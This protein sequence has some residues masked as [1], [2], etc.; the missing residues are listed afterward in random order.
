MI[1]PCRSSA[2]S[3]ETISGGGTGTYALNE[4]VT[5]L[6]AGSYTLMDTHYGAAGLPFRV[7]TERDGA[8]EEEKTVIGVSGI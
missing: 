8:V 6:Q 1:R 7:T 3:P 5:E 4:W 2:S